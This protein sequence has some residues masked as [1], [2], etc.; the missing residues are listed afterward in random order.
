MTEPAAPAHR[1]V[2]EKARS[3]VAVYIPSLNGLRAVSFLLVFCSHAWGE[4]FPG[5]FGVTVFF[6]LS[7]YLITTLLR[8]EYAKNGRI[9]FGHFWIRRALRILPPFYLV[10][11]GATVWTAIMYPTGQLSAGATWARALHVT[12]YWTIYHSQAGEPVGTTVY[13]SLAVEEH[14][15]LLFPWLF[16]LMQKLRC[17]PRQQAGVLWAL[18]AV[19][20]AW[21]CILFGLLHPPEI[22]IAFAS[23]TRMDSILYG[24]ALAVWNNPA[25]D[26]YD[27]REPQWKYVF[28]P[29]ALLLL[30]ISMLIPGGLFRETIRYSLQGVGLTILFIAAIRF[31]HWAPFRP[32]N[33]RPVAFLGIL[34]YSLYLMHHAV[35]FAV[36][37]VFISGGLTIQALLAFIISL[38]VAWL[39]YL[40]V[41][42]PCAKL[43]RRFAD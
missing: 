21:R 1:G 7:G 29:G 41:E 4:I 38:E 37:R 25:L 27:L 16:I 12:N 42:R 10:L 19:V 15:Y 6:F 14:F 8:E 34:S 24:C 30:L 20:L 36:K 33:W 17:S 35:I 31:R 23:D 32:L 28:V 13:W 39:M 11:I 43:R 2:A 40:A 3:H 9:Q 5:G 26:R 22:R 18:C